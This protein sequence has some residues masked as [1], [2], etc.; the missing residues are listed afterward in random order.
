MGDGVVMGDN[1]V[2]LADRQVVVDEVLVAGLEVALAAAKRGEYVSFYYFGFYRSG[3]GHTCVSG[4]SPD[5]FRDLG[6]LERLRHRML[7][8]LVG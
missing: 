1:F 5:V 8:S 7:H 2:R 4:G 6:L 3:D